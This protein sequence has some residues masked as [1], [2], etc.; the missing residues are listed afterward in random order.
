M[1]QVG[2]YSEN[3][4]EKNVVGIFMTCLGLLIECG[5]L[6]FSNAREKR[7]WVMKGKSCRVKVKW[8]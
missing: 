1:N 8:K 3:V 6:E 2:K 4:K 7:M 5:G